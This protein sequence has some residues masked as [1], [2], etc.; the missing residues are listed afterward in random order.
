MVAA[1]VVDDLSHRYEK[2][3][4]IRNINFTI[5]GSG[6]VGLLG[7]NGAGKSTCMNIMCG[8]LNPTMGDVKIDGL[9][10]RDKP[11]E[12]K[13]K[14]GF[15]PQQA[16]LYPEFT[17]QEY[18]TYC[19]SLRCVDKK[20]IPEA[21]E[22]AKAKCG[23]SHFTD[24]LIGALSGGYRQRVGIAQAILHQP[25]LV[26]LDEP[27]NGLDP[28]QVLAVRDL[29]QEIA[30]ERVIL[31]ST[32]ILSDVEALCDE[33]KMI[34]HGEIVFE[35]TLEA[36]SLIVEPQSMI[37]VLD[38]PPALEKLQML[39]SVTHVD[40]VNTKKYRLWFEDGRAVSQLIV[41]T[42]IEE[43]WDLRELYYEKS[44]LEEVFAR[45]S[46]KQAA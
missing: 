34:E 5:E 45:L 35:G 19:A 38:N 24:R 29:I 21:V 27:T 7:S 43:G 40:K 22:T 41:R 20:L 12:V 1:I 18:L 39:P 17:V 31:L 44:S 42:S 36:F 6:I 13:K 9:S 32:H 3:W 33:I 25:D 26:V 28:N 15:L 8:V 4:A 37:V 2:D 46:Q 10:I 30:Q 11:L 23:I 16:P 14:I